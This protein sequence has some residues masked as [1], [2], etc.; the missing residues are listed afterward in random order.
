[1]K[2]FKLIIQFLLIFLI[3]FQLNFQLSSQQIRRVVGLDEKELIKIW[4]KWL[5]KFPIPEYAIELEIKKTFPFEKD[6]QKGIYLWRPLG[7]ISLLNSNILVN[8]QKAREIFMFDREGNFLRKIGR[9]GQGPG[10]FLNPYSIT[11]N[12]KFII[13]ADNGNMRIQF[14]DLEGNYTRSFKMFEAYIDIE[15]SEDGWIYAAPLRITPDAPLIDVLDKNGRLLFS[16]G[17]ARFGG[18]KRNWQMPNMIKISLNDRNELLVGYKYFPLVCKYSKKGKLIAEYKLQHKIMKEREKIN[19]NRI[20]ENVIGSKGLMWVIQ[21][22][23]SSS[24]GFYIFYG[25]PRI[26][27]LNMTEL[28]NSRIII[29]FM[30]QNCIKVFL[31]IF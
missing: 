21:S 30:I 25:F 24:N 29:I 4:K 20:K 6:I 18:K 3:I 1:M 7:M 9:K 14:F 31:K 28:E 26:E 17:K 23:C 22:I 11:C 15:I 12:S 16:F 5:K 8:D 19:L 13:V 27:I 10:E 2:F